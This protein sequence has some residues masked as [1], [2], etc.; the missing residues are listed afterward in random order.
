MGLG[1]ALRAESKSK[2]FLGLGKG[3][4]PTVETVKQ[5]FAE[6]PSVNPLVLAV[7]PSR[8]LFVGL[9]PY[10]EEL[11]VQ[12]AQGQLVFSA[13]TSTA[14]PGYHAYLCKLL[15]MLGTDLSLS[16]VTSE[17]SCDETG[18]WESGREDQLQFE[19]KEWLTAVAK[20]VV[21]RWPE[22]LDGQI[23][24]CMPTDK[25]FVAPGAIHMPM[26]IRDR[27][28]WT[29]LATTGDGAE[30]WPWPDLADTAR[31]AVNQAVVQMW[32]DVRWRSPQNEAE[33]RT[34]GSV[35]QLLEKARSLDPH[36]PVPVREWLEVMGL[37]N[38][39]PSPD[40][41]E[42]AKAQV[43]PLI[44]YY[45]HKVRFHPS[46][47]WS[48]ELP[49]DVWI[50]PDQ[51]STFEAQAADLGVWVTTYLSKEPVTQV[52]QEPEGEKF[53]LGDSY[54]GGAAI[55]WSAS[56]NSW[57]TT[58]IIARDRSLMTCTIQVVGE[59][60]KDLAIQIAQS[61]KYKGKS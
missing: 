50:T 4:S 3:K 52:S 33:S 41:I 15:R 58:V 38:L 42:E 26:G 12:E 40:L 59:E 27:E 10:E 29:A 23:S 49:G 36:I 47:F 46:K 44:G 61:I 7:D 35:N 22:K 17:E 39:A 45:R 37:L 60:S 25:Q 20:M 51:G 11:T 31:N 57:I 5:W 9:V 2:G 24:I 54:L 14:G 6:Q 8:T 30:F 43:G 55:A 28:W 21:E 16:W 13:R 48:I 1:F 32:T 53:E 56:S 18:Y 34:L 19:M